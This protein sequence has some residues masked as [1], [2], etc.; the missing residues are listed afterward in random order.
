MRT[1][2][3]LTRALVA[4]PVSDGHGDCGSRFVSWAQHRWL[5]IAADEYS[6]V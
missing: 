4:S 3:Q 5:A 1:V 2:L 6:C